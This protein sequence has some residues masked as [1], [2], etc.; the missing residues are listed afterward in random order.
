MADKKVQVVAG[1]FDVVGDETYEEGDTLTVSEETAASFPRT[2]VL[3]EDKGGDESGDGDLP[4]LSGNEW[5][6]VA[7]AY[8]FKDVN[9]RSSSDDIKTAFANLSDEEKDDALSAVDGE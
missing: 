6:S 9:G 2:L 5:Q 7:A 4:N 8:D 1:T 3:I